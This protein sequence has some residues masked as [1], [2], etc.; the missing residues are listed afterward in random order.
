MT[1]QAILTSPAGKTVK[2]TEI[3]MKSRFGF[4]YRLLDA[5]VLLHLLYQ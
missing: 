3:G 1:I 2:N 5:H 4:K